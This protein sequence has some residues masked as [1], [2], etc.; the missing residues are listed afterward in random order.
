MS[1]NINT[2][3]GEF[4]SNVVN[5]DPE[6]TRR[7]RD[8][9][10][11][12]IAQIR[13]L[14]E[15][16]D[17]FP[18]LNSSIGHLFFGSFHR[19]TKTRPLNDIDLISCLSAEGA[20]YSEDG[21]ECRI[22]VPSTATRLS[23]FVHEET[24]LL[25]SRK[26]INKYVSGLGRVPQYIRADIG[27]DGEAAV[28]ELS[29][30]EWSFDI[31]PAFF[32]KPEADG[33]TY[34]LIPNG[35]G[36]WKKADPRVDENRIAAVNSSNNGRLLPLIRLMKYWNRRNTVPTLLPY[37]FECLLISIFSSVTQA[38]QWID[39]NASRALDS[40]A[41]LIWNP[42]PDPKGLQGDLNH[43]TILQRAEFAARARRDWELSVQ[44]Q[45]AEQNDD[46]RLAIRCWRDILGQDFPSFG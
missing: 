36:H 39:M 29:T 22:H 20:E 26:I 25:N 12:L 38:T 34:F 35:Q 14:P 40:L 1:T 17:R 46:H 15:L 7:A 44:A 4:M 18:V 31:V 45:T 6:R 41:T 43:L 16:D 2:A 19:R 42:I 32:T 28:L 30:Y 24:R 21:V 9:R 13:N 11:W 10:D 37:A 5:L 33:R 27:R 23:Q 3:F 8:S